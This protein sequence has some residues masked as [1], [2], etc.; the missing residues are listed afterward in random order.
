[1]PTY[2]L[3]PPKPSSNLSASL[4]SVHATPSSPNPFPHPFWDSD[5]SFSIGTDEDDLKRKRSFRISAEEMAIF[6]EVVSKYE[7][8]HN[9]YNFTVGREYADRA[10]RRVMKRI[11]VGVF[12]TRD[13]R[14]L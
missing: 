9:F 11:E 2:V 1:M 7:G 13:T 5:P 4:A 10:S 8:S 3:L 12:V 14:C 6:R